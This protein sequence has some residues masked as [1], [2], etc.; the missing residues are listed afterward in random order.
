M[1]SLAP[2]G[3]RV[4]PRGPLAG[5][6][7]LDFSTLLP[8]PLATLILAEAGAEV[9]KLERPGGEELRGYEPA[10]GSDSAQFAVLNAGKRSV[11][12]DAKDPEGIERLRVLL[13]SA[14]VLVEQFRPGVMARLGL[15]YDDVHAI[16]PRLVYCS[17]NGFGSSGARA[18][19][20]AHDLNYVAESGL[21]AL[22][23]GSDGTPNLP[24]ALIADIGGGALPAVI[25]ILLALRE[26]DATGVGRRVEV[27]MSEAVLT[28]APWALLTHAVSGAAPAPNTDRLNGG[29]PRY[30]VYRT[31]DRRYLA[32]APLEQRFW[33]TFCEEIG[34][35]HELRDHRND[36]AA[37]IDA[38]TAIVA[39][40]TADAWMTR[41]AG[42]DVCVT[43]V[44]DVGEART[45]PVY[46]EHGVFAYQVEAAG[47]RIAALPLPLDPGFRD[48]VFVKSAPALGEGN[49]LL[50][51]QT[52][53]GRARRIGS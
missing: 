5:V 39:T 25:N 2:R 32:V 24:P 15:G 29:S 3:A 27:A 46:A 38:V 28:F 33:E 37:T 4:N 23:A 50:A 7:V 34:L 19:L 44:R 20:A 53:E 17:I 43:I 8:G 36:P 16:N 9:I 35:P 1:E 13:E 40:R 21:L 10:F 30:R 52:F 14:D 26:R 51:A 49:E 48:G 22:V 18:G 12:F 11:V 41:F 45:D 47:E 31:A 6:R 42:L